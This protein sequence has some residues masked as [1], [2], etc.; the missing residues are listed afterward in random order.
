MARFHKL[1]VIGQL[2]KDPVVRTFANG[3]KVAKF[4]LGIDFTRRKKNPQTGEWEGESFIIDVDVFNREGSG[5]KMA[6]LVESS[7][8]KGSQVY[9]EGRLKP[10]EYT[11]KNGVKVFKPVLVVDTMQLLDPRP[12][13]S[14]PSSEE[15]TSAPRSAPATRPA[16]A[17]KAAVPAYDEGEPHEGG[18]QEEIPF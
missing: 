9:V 11:D 18:N 4:G 2:L 16:Q 8:K 15:G 6:D 12:D 14:Y 3:G 17:S 13:G 10:N 1:T 7:L 5:F